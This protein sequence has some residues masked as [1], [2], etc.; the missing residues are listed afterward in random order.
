ML[1]TVTY[2][3]EY[4]STVISMSINQICK[5]FFVFQIDEDEAV[6]YS[7]VTVL[8]TDDDYG[9][10]GDITYSKGCRGQKYS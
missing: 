9:S 1:V 3:Y 10:F 4:N 2:V 5:Y 6:G 7:V 8:F